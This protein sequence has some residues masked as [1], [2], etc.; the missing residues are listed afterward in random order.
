MHVRRNAARIIPVRAL[1]IGA[2]VG[3][4]P[5]VLLTRPRSLALT[6][7]VGPVLWAAG[8]GLGIYCRPSASETAAGFLFRAPHGDWC[9]IAH[10]LQA[11][12]RNFDGL[13]FYRG[14]ACG[15]AW[16]TFVHGPSL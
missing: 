14:K 11:R 13:N 16:T 10:G 2:A 6:P 4:G 8:L 7:G 15:V 12:T 9:A 1:G 3:G 5:A